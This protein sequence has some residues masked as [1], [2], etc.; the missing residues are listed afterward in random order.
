MPSDRSQKRTMTDIPKYNW[1]LNNVG[2]FTWK[3]R[4]NIWSFEITE[5]LKRMLSY[6]KCVDNSIFVN[7]K[8]TQSI[9]KG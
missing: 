8:Y 9:M 1:F 6:I 3:F 2:K 5:K 4:K 7:I